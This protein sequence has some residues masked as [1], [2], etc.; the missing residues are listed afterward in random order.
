M[1][2]ENQ[3]S[4]QKVINLVRTPEFQIKALIGAAIV[5]R[6]VWIAYTNFTY[7]DAFITFRYSR[8]LAEGN[9]FVYNIGERVYGTT[10]P[11]FTIL[12]SI[13]LLITRS[14]VVLGGRILNL[15]ATLGAFILLAKTLRN[16]GSSHVQ[17]F[18][19]IFLLSF[20]SK[21]WIIDTGGMETS[22]VIFFMAASWY[23]YV[24]GEI[25]WTGILLGFLLLTRPDTFLW[26]VS[27]GI[28]ELFSKPKNAF[29][30]ALAAGLTYLPW[31]IF[32][33]LYFGS[34]IPHTVIAKWVA[35]VELDQNPYS[36]KLAI[37]T[38]WL[39]PLDIPGEFYKV[40]IWLERIVMGFGAIQ[41]I[42]IFKNKKLAVLPLFGILEL[43]RI[44]FTRTT[45]FHRYF[46]PLFWVGMILFG[47][48]LG[49]I[50]NFVRISPRF[51][52]LLGAAI[53]LAGVYVSFDWGFQKALAVK[54]LQIYRQEASLQAIGL[55]LN[56]NTPPDSRVQ[57]EPLGYVGYYSD[58]TMLDEVGLV[59]PRMVEYKQ[60]GILDLHEY[61]R[62]FDPD[63]YVI[64]CDDSAYMRARVIDP[65]N[66]LVTNYDLRVTFNPLNFN[67]GE[68]A[69]SGGL[70]RL[71]CYE[72]WGKID[73]ES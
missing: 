43:I 9:G 66:L 63:Y 48:G 15:A 40:K 61:L 71:S 20:T 58:R 72:I 21:L 35:Y 60:A 68:E 62:A 34:P 13:W 30:M 17:S 23:T 27:L 28:I 22:L 6:V 42:Y 10:T 64:H 11:L 31:A 36:Y 70:P 51:K 53:L 67:A 7:E 47:L 2:Q 41:I 44:V 18:L 73:R 5:L 45:F 32:A 55:W 37:I 26:P 19:A 8:Q 69:Y 1:I 56:A 52:K 16:A 29:R 4:I 57:L 49:Y 59:T 65:V 54:D 12:T 24:K 50:W 46:I 38:G 39:G 3:K 14:D 25:R 33:T